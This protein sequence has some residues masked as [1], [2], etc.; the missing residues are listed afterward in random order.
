M[1]RYLSRADFTKLQA[2]PA[3]VFD[4]DTVVVTDEVTKPMYTYNSATNSWDALV[5]AQTN[6]LT[7]R[8]EVSAGAV[9]LNQKTK[10]FDQKYQ[11]PVIERFNSFA[12]WT[13]T[14]SG[15]AA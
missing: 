6:P 5:T 12:D 13:A 14:N 1:R 11:M 9:S 3:T 8:I 10:A 7:G 2:N 15:G 4:R